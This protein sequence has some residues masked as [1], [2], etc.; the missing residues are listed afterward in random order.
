MLVGCG[1][2][3]AH[4]V[5]RVHKRLPTRAHRGQDQHPASVSILLSAVRITS[6][7]NIRM[8]WCPGARNRG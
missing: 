1:P 6:L 3:P 5:T 2:V 4:L 7:L 8:Q